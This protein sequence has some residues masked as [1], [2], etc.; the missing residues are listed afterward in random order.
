MAGWVELDQQ[1]RS[2]DSSRICLL[3]FPVDISFCTSFEAS[4]RKQRGRKNAFEASSGK[5]K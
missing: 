2:G 3:V 5:K 1:L 4:S